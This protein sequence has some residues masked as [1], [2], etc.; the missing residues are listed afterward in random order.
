MEEEEPQ[1]DEPENNENWNCLEEADWYMAEFTN[2]MAGIA[3]K[4]L[5]QDFLPSYTSWYLSLPRTKF[6]PSGDAITTGKGTE[7][8]LAEAEA[9]VTNL[10]L[11]N[12]YLTDRIRTLEEEL[13]SYKVLN[14]TRRDPE[15][16]AA[17]MVSPQKTWANVAK[18]LPRPTQSRETS[19][20]E[21]GTKTQHT[22][23][24][25]ETDHNP[26]ANPHSLIIRVNPPVPL[27]QRPNGIETRK[28]INDMLERKN[29]PHYL[30]VMALGYS[31]AGNIKIT[32][33]PTCKASDLL[34]YGQEIA[35]L[36]MSNEVLSVLPDMEHYHVKINKVPT[37]CGNNEP[38]TLSMIQ[39]ELCTYIPPYNDM[40]VWRS[41]KWLGSEETICAKNFASIVID[42]ANKAD[43]DAMLSLKSVYLFNYRCTI[44]PYVDRPQIYAC[45]KCGMLSHRTETCCQP[46]CLK[47]GAKDHTMNDH[48]ENTSLKCVNC[49]EQHASSFKE[50]KA[51]R[52]RMGLPAATSTPQHPKA[53]NLA[54]DNPEQTRNKKKPKNK[55]YTTLP[56]PEP[57]DPLEHIGLSASDILNILDK[58]NPED[59]RTT[60]AKLIQEKIRMKPLHYTP[61][62]PNQE[63]APHTPSASASQMDIEM[64]QQYSTPNA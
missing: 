16:V 58:E 36:I 20:P 14:T 10:S 6:T 5:W 61:T 15:T 41:P 48:P 43:R 51:R 49:K 40:R 35:A 11:S 64:S 42:L 52:S 25:S 26:T 8:R 38:M 50:C 23:T 28:K 39:S 57:T 1:K 32:T 17:P 27:D 60:T 34:E 13:L 59:Q 53:A 46:R 37:H 7:E 47:C 21:N 62:G 12:A 31:M 19:Q 4:G 44:T 3:N 54:T 22:V 29:L 56:T 2:I 30:R 45:S 63:Q 24:P 18:T 33:A 55:Q 9:N